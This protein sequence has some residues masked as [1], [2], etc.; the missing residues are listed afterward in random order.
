MIQNVLP[1]PH[2]KTYA[3]LGSPVVMVDEDVSG[4]KRPCVR[5]YCGGAGT[6]VLRPCGLGSSD[7]QDT[8]VTAT[9]GKDFDLQCEQIVSGT[10]TLV[11]VYWGK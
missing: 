5:I 1:T 10:A 4:K 6:M 11:T 3:N 2:F 9:A 7:A 8:T